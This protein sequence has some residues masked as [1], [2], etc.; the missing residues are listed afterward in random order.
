MRLAKAIEQHDL[1]GPSPRREVSNHA[2][3]RCDA[4]TAANQNDAVR[5]DPGERKPTLWRRNL[6]FI[7]VF[8]LVVKVAG[9]HTLGLALDGYLNVVAL[10]GR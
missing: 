5:L 8:D 10:N 3:Q 4:H 1:I 7:S 9:D 2:H 6:Q